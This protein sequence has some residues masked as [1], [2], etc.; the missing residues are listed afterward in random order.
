MSTTKRWLTLLVVVLAVA[1]AY[2]AA[3]SWQTHGARA[4]AATR[5]DRYGQAMRAAGTEVTAF[6]NMRHDRAQESVDAV[7]AGATGDFR[8]H[9]V[10]SADQVIRAMKRSRSTMTGHVVW[11]GVSDLSPTQATVIVATSGTVANRRTGGRQEAREFRFQVSL[12]RVGGRWLT[13]DLQFVG[14]AR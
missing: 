3:L 5:Q 6:V 8:A 11:S 13:S 10:S 2:G 7:A 1:A 4:D 12:L 9:Y 14:G